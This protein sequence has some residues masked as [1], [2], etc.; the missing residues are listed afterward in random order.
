MKPEMLSDPIFLIS[1]VFAVII[2]GISKG[3]FGGLALFAVPILSLSISPVQAAGILL[4][5][6][7]VMDWV[8]IW[9]YRKHWDKRLLLLMLPGA[10][11]GIAIGGLLADRVS[12]DFVRVCVGFIAVA[13][14]VYA[15]LGPKFRTGGDWLKGNR[16]MAWASGIA[17]GFTSFV[18]HAGGPPFQTYALPQGLDKRIYAGTAVMFFMVVNAVKLIPYAMLGQFDRT[19]LTISAALIPLAPIGVLIGVWLVKRI[20]QQT[21]YRVMYALI[22]V[23]GVKLLW[24]GLI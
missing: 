11:I 1:A 16:P 14:P 20:D 7:I 13:F 15:V 24:D 9:A 18:A 23:T 2:T 5:I 6:L 12:E 19:N 17:A 22:F 21:F 10:M 4:P 3:G 8:S